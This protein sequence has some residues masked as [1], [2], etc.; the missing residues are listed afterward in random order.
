M[1]PG[2]HLNGLHIDFWIRTEEIN[3]GIL[4]I[5]LREAGTEQQERLAHLRRVR[6]PVFVLNHADYA[7][8]PHA[9]IERFKQWVPRQG[10]D[11]VGIS[12][13]ARSEAGQ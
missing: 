10:T 7:A 6:T 4:L 3:V 13:V 5:D 11:A 9:T 1:Q 12:L 2:R 8:D